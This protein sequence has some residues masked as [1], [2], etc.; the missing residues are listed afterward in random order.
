MRPD[1]SSVELLAAVTR[2]ISGSGDRRFW[3]AEPDGMPGR[4]LRNSFP[5]VRIS[6][7]RSLARSRTD[8]RAGC[9]D[10]RPAANSARFHSTARFRSPTLKAVR[11]VG[12]GSPS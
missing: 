11:H 2:I 3:L 5:S 7:S 8:A 6:S 4:A 9:R 12:P 1:P 10:L